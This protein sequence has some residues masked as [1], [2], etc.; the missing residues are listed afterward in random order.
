MTSALLCTRVPPS[1]A[2]ITSLIHA[3]RQQGLDH[4]PLVQLP[5]EAHNLPHS[6]VLRGDVD[7]RRA[8]VL[9]SISVFDVV[10]VLPKTPSLRGAHALFRVLVEVYSAKVPVDTLAAAVPICHSVLLPWTGALQT[11]ETLHV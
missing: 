8:L 9:I 10:G 5:P 7:R 2:P 11:G 4:R 3:S 1:T 6:S